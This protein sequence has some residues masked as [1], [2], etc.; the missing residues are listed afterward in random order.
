MVGKALYGLNVAARSIIAAPLPAAAEICEDV[1][2]GMAV[3]FPC[4]ATHV[5]HARQG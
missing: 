2:G 4:A 5:H 3:I 1:V